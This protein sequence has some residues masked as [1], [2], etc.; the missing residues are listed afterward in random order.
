MATASPPS[1]LLEDS[2]SQPWR[3][4][5]QGKTI[6]NNKKRFGV[7]PANI[8]SREA[9]GILFWARPRWL[10]P[11]FLTTQEAEVRRIEVQSQPG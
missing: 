5:R 10:M 2:G 7:T 11:V 6:N 1:F 8:N 3:Q 9:L 4:N